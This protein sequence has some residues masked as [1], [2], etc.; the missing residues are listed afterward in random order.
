MPGS[1]EGFTDNLTELSDDN[2]SAFVN[3]VGPQ[4]DGN[5]D[6]GHDEKENNVPHI[7]LNQHRDESWVEP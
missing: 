2:L 3:N 4:P 1:T 5:A 7:K 6:A